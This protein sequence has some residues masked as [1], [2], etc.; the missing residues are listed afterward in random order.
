MKATQV[1]N[2]EESALGY[3]IN[4]NHH[5]ATYGTIELLCSLL[6]KHKGSTINQEIDCVVDLGSGPGISSSLIASYTN[7]KKVIAADSSSAMLQLVPKLMGSISNCEV[8]TQ[9]KNLEKERIDLSNDSADLIISIAVFSYL[10]NLRNVLEEA[11]RILKPGG[12]FAFDIWIHTGSLVPHIDRSGNM[13]SY[14]HHKDTLTYFVESMGF[15][16][17]YS[18]KDIYQLFLFQKM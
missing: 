5:T 2:T 14:S 1:W 15:K 13:L 3:L 18:Q 10:E 17:L 11:F 8:I 9:V 12:Y 16:L 7:C 6:Q 4:L